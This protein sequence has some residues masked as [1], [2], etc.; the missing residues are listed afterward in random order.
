[1]CSTSSVPV[2]LNPPSITTILYEARSLK[3]PYRRAIASPLLW[4]SFPTPMKSTSYD[5][6]SARSFGSAGRYPAS[7]CRNY[8]IGLAEAWTRLHR[9]DDRRRSSEP[10]RAATSRNRV[11][12]S[13]CLSSRRAALPG[14]TDGRTVPSDGQTSLDAPSDVPF[15]NRCTGRCM[16]AQLQEMVAAPGSRPRPNGY[17][18]TNPAKLSE[19]SDWIAYRKRS[20]SL[21]SPRVSSLI[22]STRMVA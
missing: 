8:A 16:C 2:S 1:M 12:E 9:S 14:Q 19:P 22:P 3:S 17:T 5:I 20:S 6:F 11:P 7:P 4:D 21:S 13:S 10:G 18:S 15:S